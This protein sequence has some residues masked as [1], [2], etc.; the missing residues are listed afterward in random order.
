MGVIVV[1]CPYQLEVGKRVPKT[2]KYV[3]GAEIEVDHPVMFVLAEATAEEYEQGL[4]DEH[5][6]DAF[7]IALNRWKLQFHGPVTYY[8][9]VSAD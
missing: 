5:G 9:K 3:H 8:Y 2:F 7:Q 6:Q 4:H 1:A